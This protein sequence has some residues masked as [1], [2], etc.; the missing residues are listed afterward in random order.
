[1]NR[2]IFI[3]AAIVLAIG[4][5]LFLTRQLKLPQ[6]SS[7]VPPPNRDAASELSPSRPVTEDGALKDAGA[8]PNSRPDSPP[9]TTPKL[10][11]TPDAPSGSPVNS[12]IPNQ[13]V[14]VGARTVVPKVPP[15]DPNPAAG[16]D[17]EKVRLMLRDYRTLYRENPV[18]TNAE[19]MKAIMGG[20]PRQAQLGPPEGQSLSAEGELLDRWGTPYFFHQLSA[21]SMEVRSAGPDKTLWTSDD[22]VAK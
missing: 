5:S 1:M 3:V 6:E 13:P 19:I 8:P 18:G 20:N 12:I 2:R 7:P 17:V 22:I 21:D 10:V 15:P 9:A 14:N 11:A 16:V 4:L